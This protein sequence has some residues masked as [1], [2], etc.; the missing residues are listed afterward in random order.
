MPQ[1]W[2]GTKLAAALLARSPTVLH[3]QQQMKQGLQSC[4]PC[5]AH[6]YGA[7]TITVRAAPMPHTLRSCASPHR[8]VDLA[9]PV[10]HGLPW[11]TMPALTQTHCVCMHVPGLPCPS[12]AVLRAGAQG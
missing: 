1:V 6:N 7:R 11:F 3:S 8:P 10:M 5:G 2:G 12:G 9:V 4:P